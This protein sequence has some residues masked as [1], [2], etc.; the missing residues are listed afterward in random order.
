MKR[1]FATLAAATLMTAPAYAATFTITVGNSSPTIPVPQNDFATQ[2]NGIGLFNFTTVAS[3][4]NIVGGPARVTFR[5]IV[6]ESG[7]VDRFTAGPVTGTE[8]N[9]ANFAT[10]PLIG[11]GSAVFGTGALPAFFT[12]GAVGNPTFGIGTANFGIFLDKAY[13]PGSTIT[14]LKTVYFGFD[15]QI[16]NPDDDNHDDFI[17]SA[18]IEA[19]PEPSTWAMMLAGFGIIGFCAR[20]RQTANARVAFS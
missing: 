6:S 7:F 2:L 3:A 11:V 14:G 9:D 17:V 13:A 12:S 1:L 16:T 15:D 20:R 5:Y 8:N 19:V 4:L 18:T 10:Q